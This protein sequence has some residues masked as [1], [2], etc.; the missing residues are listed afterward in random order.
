MRRM[1]SCEFLNEVLWV[2]RCGEETLMR[3][4]YRP[5][6]AMVVGEDQSEKDDVAPWV[7]SETGSTP[8]AK[9]FQIS[10]GIF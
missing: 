5:S 4:Y 1:R 8:S 6:S 10:F 7:S 9:G 2:R 3:K